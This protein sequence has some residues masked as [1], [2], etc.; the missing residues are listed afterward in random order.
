M[1]FGLSDNLLLQGFQG[2]GMYGDGE[3]DVRCYSVK[4]VTTRKPHKCPGNFSGYMHDIPVGARAVREDAII[5]GK[6]CHSYTCELC[7]L[8][9]I[10]YEDEEDQ[11]D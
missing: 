5:D 7:V 10:N 3:G 8:R 9:W 4:V 1:T 2:M 11:G 6:R